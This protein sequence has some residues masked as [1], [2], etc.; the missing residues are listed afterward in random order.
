MRDQRISLLLAAACLS[1]GCSD[2][3]SGRGIPSSENS[4]PAFLFE[5]SK[6]VDLGLQ[7]SVDGLPRQGVVVQ[8]QDALLDPSL[9]EH[10]SGAL[11]FNGITNREGLCD[12]PLKF[13]TS[14]EVCDIVLQAPGLRGPFTISSLR[15]KWGPFAPSARV[16]V[17][18]ARL[19]AIQIDLEGE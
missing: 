11:Y 13:P 8:L 19:G 16:T 6:R 3:S 15:E 12:G 2:S 18:V 10:L 4:E 1:G 7:V 14:K 5:T 9:D 17:P